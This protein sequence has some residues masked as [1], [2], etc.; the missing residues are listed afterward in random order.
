MAL[1]KECSVRY[2]ILFFLLAATGCQK[3]T[4]QQETKAMATATAPKEILAGNIS[5]NAQSGEIKYTLPQAALVRIRI[6]LKDGGPLLRNLVDWEKREKG[7]HTEIWDKKDASGKVNFGNRTDFML[8]L[9]CLPLNTKERNSYSGAIKGFRKSPRLSITFPEGTEKNE[10]GMSVLKEVVPVRIS[11]GEK[12]KWI[13][14]TKYE[15]GMFID[16]IFL[17]E[18]EEG[19]NPFTYQLNTKGLN[20]GGHVIT[21]NMIGYEGEIG[22]E[23]ALVEVKK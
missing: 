12:D 7:E 11:L 14:E 8:V 3:H 21:V 9:A 19:S 17:M 2:L 20:E 13:I 6:G 1:G 4:D 15:L 22:T 18:D 10:K 5:F 16:N 23:S